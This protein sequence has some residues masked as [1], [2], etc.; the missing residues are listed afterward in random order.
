MSNM[1]TLRSFLI[2]ILITFWGPVSFASTQYD[3][4]KI[5]VNDEPIT[6]NEIDMRIYELAR[7]KKMDIKSVDFDGP[8]KTEAIDLLIEETLLD[9]RA[10]ELFVFLSDDDLD[11][12]VE[13]FRKQRNISQLE[14]EALLERQQISLSD[15]RKTYK[16]QIRRNRVIVREIRSTINMDEDEIRKQYENSVGTEKLIRARHI[17]LRLSSN[18]KDADVEKVRSKALVLKSRI[19]NGDSFVK[20]ADESSEDPSVTANHGDLGFFKKHEMVPEFSQAAFLLEI[21]EISDPVRTPFGFHL[22]EVLEKKEEPKESFEK[23]KNKLM[24]MEYQ[25]QFQEKYKQYITGLKENAKIIF[26]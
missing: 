14:F 26:K 13:Q 4:I 7:A 9:V 2:F 23:V 3:F 18:A 11:E 24:Q 22:I 19:E 12:E 8:L 17:L 10:D 25:K 6:N 20:I 1:L 15:F 16:R 21:G 5:L